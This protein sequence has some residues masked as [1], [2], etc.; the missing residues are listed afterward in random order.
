MTR[1]VASAII[2]C[3]DPELHHARPTRDSRVTSCGVGAGLNVKR[4]DDSGGRE[5]SD[6]GDEVGRARVHQHMMRTPGLAS[7][8]ATLGATLDLLGPVRADLGAEVL[9]GRRVN[10]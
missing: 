1:Q 3:R 8:G 4:Q 7:T 2:E 9:R 10:Q 6:E 5:A